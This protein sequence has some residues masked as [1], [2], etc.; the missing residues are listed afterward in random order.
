MVIQHELTGSARPFG[1][2]VSPDSRPKAVVDI[3]RVDADDKLVEHWD[4]Q[5][6]SPKQS[7]NTKG[8]V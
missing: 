8:M 5:Q 1:T 2:P 4:V 7:A 3:F 6:V